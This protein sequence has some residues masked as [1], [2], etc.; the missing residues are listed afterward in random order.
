MFLDHEL[1]SLVSPR[2]SARL[3]MSRLAEPAGAGWQG[4]SAQAKT[5][6]TLSWRIALSA[7]GRSWYSQNAKPFARP[8]SLS[9]TSLQGWQAC[10]AAAS[11]INSDCPC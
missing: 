6:L 9:V 2:Y 11:L 5:E 3:C 7:E 10:Q 8:V 1:Y 4:G